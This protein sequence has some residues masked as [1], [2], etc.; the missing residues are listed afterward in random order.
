[1][2]RRRL[3]AW[4]AAA[5]AAF[6]A[7]GTLTACSSSPGSASAPPPPS[8]G[9]SDSFSPTAPT[10]P[11]GVLGL[12][13]PSASPVAVRSKPVFKVHD[14]LPNA[15]SNAVALTIDDGPSRRYTP[16]VL[17]LLR[18]Y[19]V[20]ATFSVVGIEAHADKDLIRQIAADGHTLANHTMTH[21]Q[22]FSRRSEAQIQQ[23]IADTQS[24]VV[25]AAGAEPKL[26]RSPGGDWSP[27]VF[28]AVA[29]YGMTPID[30]DVDPRDWSR[31]GT[32][33]ISEKLLA[34]KPGDILLCH[35]GGGDRSQT[36]EALRTVL[37]ALKAKGYSFVTL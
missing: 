37:P 13:D 2:T 31:P 1:M 6:G 7:G 9:P 17:Q 27:A 14:L 18:K 22:P 24:V 8:E 30:W 10:E 33:K 5:A 28:A 34:A 16:E 15:P 3:I 32:R 19:D 26:F 36:V 29:K 20:R 25:D 21:P 35:D 12:P 23:Q 11:P 4:T